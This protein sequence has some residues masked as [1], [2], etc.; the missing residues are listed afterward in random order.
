MTKLK[1]TKKIIKSGKAST[2]VIFPKHWMQIMGLDYT[3]GSGNNMVNMVLD[4]N[5][6]TIT[7]TKAD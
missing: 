1:D 2:S 3:E 7:I 6:K 4:V 5:K